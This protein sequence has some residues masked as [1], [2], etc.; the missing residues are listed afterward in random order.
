MATLIALSITFGA[1]ALISLVFLG[2]QVHEDML[3][4]S[5]GW[6]IGTKYAYCTII[7]ASLFIIFAAA[8]VLCA[9]L[10]MHMSF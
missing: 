4:W 2:I 5:T 6:K 9:V 8:C 1:L 10:P 3:L 7:F